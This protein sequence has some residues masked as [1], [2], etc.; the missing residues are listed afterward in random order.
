MVLF[1]YPSFLSEEE[2]FEEANRNRGA[3][4]KIQWERG[5]GLELK[6]MIFQA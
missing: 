4:F 3:F 2:F 5:E 6:D 1:H